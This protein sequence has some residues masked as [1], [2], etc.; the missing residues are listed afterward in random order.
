ML[1]REMQN[2]KTL[3]FQIRTNQKHL[4]FNCYCSLKSKNV[5]KSQ[6]F[7]HDYYSYLKVTRS[8]SVPFIRINN[9]N[10][11][12]VAHFSRGSIMQE[13]ALLENSQIII[14]TTGVVTMII[15]KRPSICVRL[16]KHQFQVSGSI[17][18][19]RGFQIRSI[20]SSI[21]L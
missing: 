10:Q 9:L 19:F 4:Q 13:H 8:I 2:V 14:K 1:Q 21:S 16:C 12:T 18:H 6:Y 15:D 20:R 3:F 7:I 5:Y 11:K 17:D